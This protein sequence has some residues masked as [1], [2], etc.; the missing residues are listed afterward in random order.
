MGPNALDRP[1]FVE[2]V[3]TAIT[4][5][6][7]GVPA[8][9]LKSSM[10]RAAIEF[11][12]RTAEAFARALFSELSQNPQDLLGL[13]S[14]IILG[15]AHPRILARHG[16]SL[17]TEGRRLAVVLERGGQSTR[18]QQILEML[19]TNLPAQAPAQAE[20]AVKEDAQVAERVATIETLLREADQCIARGRRKEAIAKLQQI[21]KLDHDR[22]DVAR[23]IRDLRR[24][25]ESGRASRA[26]FLKVVL[27]MTIVG[28]LGYL[29]VQREQRVRDRWEALPQVTGN[30]VN[31]LQSRLA[32]IESLLAQEHYWAGVFSAWRERDELRAQIQHIQEQA[33]LA[34][35]AAALQKQERLQQAE[36]IRLR[37]ML[38]V[39]NGHF[40]EALTDLRQA[41]EL[42][43]DQ[44]EQRPRVQ[45][46]ISAIEAWKAGKP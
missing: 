9:S 38:S 33:A 26:T 25:Q 27:S 40:E 8:R 44:W 11:D 37:G 31:A 19:S 13:E 2:D 4:G 36:D 1:L 20:A 3:I 45:R 46:D 6:I 12:E 21:L 16:I 10:E 15:L 43:G 30:D 7:G 34:E 24:E 14:L 42:G 32:S 29:L 39:K 18:A 28:A 17:E 22:F 23:M 41:L 5:G 35:R